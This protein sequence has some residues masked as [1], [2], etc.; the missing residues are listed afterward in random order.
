[1]SEREVITFRQT[2]CIDGLSLSLRVRISHA[3]ACRLLA[4]Q[5]P[6]DAVDE[7]EAA[8]SQAGRD[9]A[10]APSILAQARTRFLE[11]LLRAWCEF[12]KENRGNDVLRPDIFGPAPAKP[13]E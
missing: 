9:L 8:L 2:E 10:A 7:L 1:V 4:D 3:A 11:S 13:D 5:V 6:A 12:L